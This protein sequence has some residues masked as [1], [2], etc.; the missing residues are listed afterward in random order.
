MSKKTS[1][2]CDIINYYYASSTLLKAVLMIHKLWRRNYGEEKFFPSREDEWKKLCTLYVNKIKL[3]KFTLSTR[4][5]N[6]WN[7]QKAL[8]LIL[9]PRFVRHYILISKQ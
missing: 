9:Y 2:K 1:V 8:S 3:R 6:S 5:K 7:F 4:V